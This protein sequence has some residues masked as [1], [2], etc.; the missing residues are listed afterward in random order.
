MNMYHNKYIKIVNFL[1]H[2]SSE[3]MKMFENVK[4]MRSCD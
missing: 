1:T 4:K 2:L 3:N